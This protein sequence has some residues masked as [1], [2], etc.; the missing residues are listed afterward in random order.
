M[1]S[2]SWYEVAAADPQV[3]CFFIFGDSLNDCGNNN[4]IN[5]KAKANYKPYGIDFP[6]GATG[7][8]TNGRTTVDF[9][10]E[11][12]G[13]DNPIPP[14]TTAKGEKILQGINY[15]S[16][17]AGIL[18]ETGKHLG[19]NV[20]LGTQVQ[21]H[22][23]TLSRIVA[24][25]GDNETAAEHLNAC[26][27]YMAIGSNDYLNNYFLPDHYKTSNEFSVEEF[28]THLVSTYGDR[29]R[30]LYGYG[31]RKIAVVG[32]GKIGCVPRTM[33]LFGTNGTKCIQ[34]VNLAAQYFNK[35]LKKLVVDLNKE[36]KDAKLIYINSY[37]MGDGDPTILGFKFI[38][39]GCCNPRG[40]GQCVKDKVPCSSRREYVFWDS[41]H[42]T[43][44]SHRTFADRTYKSLL[45]SDSDPFD[46]HSLAALDLGIKSGRRA[47]ETSGSGR[48]KH[49]NVEFFMVIF[50]TFFLN[51]KILDVLGF[52]KG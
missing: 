12:L 10:A 47:E 6:D 9:L 16:G 29:I 24:R 40:D 44:A 42:P 33:D 21:N 46:L 4:H 13:F 37:G 8:F 7:R 28:A 18:D 49:R 48:F 36:L 52:W 38:T 35:Q 26:V 34:N 22:Q 51:R 1:A 43:E 3:P 41:F 50:C 31:A 19:H 14:F 15:A 25:K 30:T 20:A 45:P 11:H 5:T 32:V 23:I 17:S 39:R 2:S 27:Y